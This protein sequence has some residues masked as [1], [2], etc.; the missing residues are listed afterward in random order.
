M[1]GVYGRPLFSTALKPMGASPEELA[2]MAEAFALGEGDIVKDDHGLIDHSFCPFEERVKRCQEAIE[3]SNAMTGRNTLY[4]PNILA[5]NDE[6]EKQAQFAVRHGVRGVLL[7]PF[8]VGP[9]MIRYL[10]RQYNLIIMAHPAMTGTYFNEFRHGI[11]PAILLGTV[12]RLFGA[13]ISVYPNV[14]GRFSFTHEECKDIS[15]A[16][17]SPLGNIKPSFPAPAG[18]MSLENAGDMAKLY[19]EDAVFLIGGALHTYSDNLTKSTRVFMD[20][21]SKYFSER[22]T[23]PQEKSISSCELS[24]I[25]NL[26]SIKE[27]LKFEEGFKWSGRD[28]S[29]YN[30]SGDVNFKD[31]SRQELIGRFGEKTQFDLRYFEIEPGGFSSL[32]R[33]VHEHVIICLR[34]E[35]VLISGDSETELKLNDIAYV[36]PMRPHRLV[37]RGDEPFGFFCI[38]DHMRDRPITG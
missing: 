38:V 13:D 22:I 28:A 32:E 11:T 21:I 2:N 4:F 8:L 1:V 27:H 23:P 12:F 29:A 24:T 17:K 19:G 20:E 14:G 16:L 18:G 15:K 30:I 5:G 36:S 34:G 6:I 7:S 33:H 25:K 35:G 26:Q 31:I 37:N 10:A 9:D 3:R